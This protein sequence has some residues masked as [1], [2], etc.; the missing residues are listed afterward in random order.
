MHVVVVVAFT[1]FL[2]LLLFLL[3]FIYTLIKIFVCLPSFAFDA[4]LLFLYFCSKIKKYKKKNKQHFTLAIF[5][6]FLFQFVENCRKF[7]HSSWEVFL[8]LLMIVFYTLYCLYVH[9]S[10]W[11]SYVQSLEL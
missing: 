5:G 6:L 10:M 9:A 2:L 3:F 7:A 11:G 4:L 8:N 1:R